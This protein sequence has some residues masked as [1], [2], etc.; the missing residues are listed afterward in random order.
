MLTAKELEQSQETRQRIAELCKILK[1]KPE[2]VVSKIQDLKAG[3]ESATVLTTELKQ[4]LEA[5]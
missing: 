2:D 4:Q 3:L 5:L 1:C